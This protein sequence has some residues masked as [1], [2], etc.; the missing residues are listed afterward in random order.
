MK[1]QLKLPDRDQLLQQAGQP[2]CHD[3]ALLVEATLSGAPE[4][5]RDVLELGCGSGLAAL[6]IR[7]QR[8]NWRVT[9]VELQEH[10]ADMARHNAGA[11]GL[12]FRVMTADLREWTSDRRYHI[13]AA[14]PPHI[15]RDQG[16]LP[17]DES[18]AIARHELT[19]TMPDVIDAVHR[20]LAPSGVAW[21]V[22]PLSRREELAAACH[23]RN[24]DLFTARTQ[25]NGRT[26]AFGV[27][28]AANA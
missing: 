3:T 14:N 6:Q 21:L 17:S 23:D 28:F 11:I 16:R 15:P 4:C 26:A 19:C 20:L 9:G 7:A 13:I 18:R 2:A 8:P 12:P 22:Y 1:A 5:P 27:R 24:L 10:L 25:P